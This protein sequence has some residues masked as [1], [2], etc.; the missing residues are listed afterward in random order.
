MPLMLASIYFSLSPCLWC[1]GESALSSL[2]ELSV[3]PSLLRS[4]DIWYVRTNSMITRLLFITI[5]TGLLTTIFAIASIICV[6]IA[7]QLNILVD[8]HVI[9]ARSNTP[10]FLLDY[11]QFRTMPPLCEFCDGQFKYTTVY[12]LWKENRALLPTLINALRFKSTNF[13][14][15]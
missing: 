3:I 9:Q 14:R 4:H 8:Q 11:I 1:L 10:V 12:S 5:N 7:P 13:Q 15:K 6:S 2:R